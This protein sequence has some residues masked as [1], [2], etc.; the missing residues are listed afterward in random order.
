MLGS[1]TPNP[2]PR[3]AGAAVAVV[4][5]SS[6]L[7]IDCGRAATQR[8][9]DAGLDLTAVAAVLIT[10]HHSDHL[11]DLATFAIARWVA[12][13]TSPLQIVA[14]AGPAAAFAGACLDGFDDQLFHGQGSASAARRPAIRAVAFDATHEVAV[15][16]GAD[17]WTVSSVL[18]DHHPVE[19]AVGYLIE[20]GGARVA[21]SG[22]TAVCDGMRRLAGGVH[23]LVH[24]ALLG[25]RVSPA[26]LEWNASARSVGELA[27][28]TRPET[29]VL[30]HLIP[31]PARAEDELA[32]LDEVREGGYTGRTLVAHDLMR[33]TAG[34]TR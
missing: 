19:P 10:H 29:L 4:G 27:A 15:V 28:A 23:V 30:T 8:A 2:D 24:Q 33:L 14:P 21:V 17:G 6:W 16:L 11:S 1:G 13:A 5:E 34:S 9:L 18:V 7:L 12:G 26:L 22:D 3:R 25:A 31:A 20:S 32:Y